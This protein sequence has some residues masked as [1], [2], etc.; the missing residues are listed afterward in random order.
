MVQLFVKDKSITPRSGVVELATA[1]TVDCMISKD[2]LRFIATRQLSYD[3]WYS[4]FI[5]SKSAKMVT[6]GKLS[7]DDHLDEKDGKYDFYVGL[8]GRYFKPTYLK[9]IQ[10]V[11]PDNT[12]NFWIL[13]G[14]TIDVSEKGEEVIVTEDIIDPTTCE[15]IGENVGV[16]KTIY[17]LQISTPIHHLQPHKRYVELDLILWRLYH[18]ICSLIGR[19]QI[20]APGWPTDG[21]ALTSNMGPYL[22]TYLQYQA[23]V[24]RWN[25]YAWS[26]AFLLEADAQGESASIVI[27][28]TNLTCAELGPIS[29]N[30]MVEVGA[31]GVAFGNNMDDI[32]REYTAGG[33]KDDEGNEL[34]EWMK[35]NFCAER[36]EEG[37]GDLDADEVWVKK[38]DKAIAPLTIYNQGKDSVLDE[39]IYV[40][41]V[42]KR[43]ERTTNGSGYEGKNPGLVSEYTADIELTPGASYDIVS[44]GG[45]RVYA[46]I[47]ADG[48]IG[49]HFE[50]TAGWMLMGP[51]QRYRAVFAIA[52]C[53]GIDRELET[54]TGD[55]LIGIDLN[56]T[57]TWMIGDIEYKKTT[58]VTVAA[59]GIDSDKVYCKKERKQNY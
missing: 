17:S 24:A 12:G 31:V 11:A 22:G 49:S 26:S 51:E 56:V 43:G 40:R 41:T 57:A 33:G 23:L 37:E 46:I 19:L 13:P 48:S 30:L 6:G 16:R 44:V 20:Y 1:G 54:Q 5:L 10:Q 35:P 7:A 53:I 39:G 27:G 32:E 59:L 8:N 52:S 42:L 25:H 58:T 36:A 38:F 28:Y 55:P 47:N 18:C 14:K 2:N 45:K 34:P 50:P 9:T 21:Y 4:G 3:D 29:M 15:V